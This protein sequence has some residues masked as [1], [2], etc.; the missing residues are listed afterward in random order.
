MGTGFFSSHPVFYPVILSV[1]FAQFVQ[2]KNRSQ[3]GRQE[4]QEATKPGALAKLTTTVCF[5]CR[6]SSN[7]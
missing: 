6:V 7:S 2:P 3:D 1:G 4:A 5:T